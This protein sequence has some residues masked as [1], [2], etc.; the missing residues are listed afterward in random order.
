L[1]AHSGRA[2]VDGATKTMKTILIFFAFSLTSCASN[3]VEGTIYCVHKAVWNIT[4][5]WKNQQP[6]R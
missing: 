5:P 2:V 1:D 6:K 4:K 3:G